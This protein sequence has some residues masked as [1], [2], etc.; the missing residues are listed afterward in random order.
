M[1]TQRILIYIPR[2][3]FR[4][5]PNLLRSYFSPLRSSREQPLVLSFHIS[6]KIALI[7]FLTTSMHSLKV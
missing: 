1:Y 5:F 3:M 2:K 6:S 7:G 4:L